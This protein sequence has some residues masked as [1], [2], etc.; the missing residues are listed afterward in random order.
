MRVRD[1]RLLLGQFPDNAR[2]LV[3]SGGAPKF[4]SGVAEGYEIHD[5]KVVFL[6]KEQFSYCLHPS[7]GLINPLAEPWAGREVAIL[8]EGQ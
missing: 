2:V 7:V 1:L 3:S 6:T 8:L 4:L 5:E